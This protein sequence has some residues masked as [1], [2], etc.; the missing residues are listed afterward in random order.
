M[1]SWFLV[2]C[3]NGTSFHRITY[4]Q[5]KFGCTSVNKA[6]CLEGP[7]S[8]WKNSNVDVLRRK[9]RKS[10]INNGTH[11]EPNP[12]T[13]WLELQAFCHWAM[14]TGQP[15]VVNI[16]VHLYLRWESYWKYF[17]TVLSLYVLLFPLTCCRFCTAL[18]YRSRRDKQWRLWDPVDV[19]RVPS[20]NSYR[21]F[22]TLML[23]W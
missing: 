15:H 12:D 1:C 23:D 18:T 8:C 14:T 13:L 9:Q 19:E 16:S 22:T 21:D 10:E 4:K 20:S 6:K 7:I 3:C 2:A 11:Q 17:I 5:L